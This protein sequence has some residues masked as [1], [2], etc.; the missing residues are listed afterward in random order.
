MVDDYYDQIIQ[1]LAMGTA[2]EDLTTS[3]KKQLV[4]KVLDFQLVIGKLYKVGLD[5]ILW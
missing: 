2:P 4:F 3:H 1:F 5:E